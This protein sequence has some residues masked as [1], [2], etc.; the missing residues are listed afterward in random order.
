[1]A[2]SR[3]HGQAPVVLVS[4]TCVHAATISAVAGSA[5]ISQD[6]KFQ[7]C[8]VVVV[9]GGSQV[10]TLAGTLAMFHCCFHSN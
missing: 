8:V 4:G 10:G 6:L 3:E 7:Y 1:M 9:V 2:V 5:C